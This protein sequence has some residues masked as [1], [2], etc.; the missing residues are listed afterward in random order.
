MWLSQDMDGQQQGLKA[1]GIDVPWLDH[2]Q[3]PRD[4]PEVAKGSRC[5]MKQMELP[6]Y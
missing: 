1:G 3:V 5:G 6:W 2:E 4:N